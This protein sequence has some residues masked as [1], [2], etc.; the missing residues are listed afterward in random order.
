[1]QEHTAR[2]ET[3]IEAPASR[4][5]KALITPSTIKKYFFGANVETDWGVGNPI[6]WRG[7]SK[8][9][10]FEDKGEVLVFQPESRLRMSHWSAMSGTTDA[11][12]NYHTVTF[13]LKPESKGTRVVLTQGNLTGGVRETDIQ[14]RSEYE[15]NWAMV[16]E[17]LAKVIQEPKSQS[18]AGSGV[19]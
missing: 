14:N 1:M 10:P 4:V 19:R 3:L 17:N 9:K 5:W 8:G 15:K 11:P 7:E 6:R 18:G 12:E 13:D 16:L 2:V